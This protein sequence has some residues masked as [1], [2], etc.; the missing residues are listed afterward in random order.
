[1]ELLT[2]TELVTF[3]RCEERH[4]I[5]YNKRL[6]P[7][8]E[9]PALAMGSAVHAG[10]EH[11]SARVALD[12]MKS[13]DN[14]GWPGSSV[15]ERVRRSQ[16][17]AMVG[18]ALSQWSVWPDKHEVQFEVPLVN[19]KTGRS[20]KAHRLSGVFDG[21]WTGTHPAAPGEWVLGEWKTASAVNED[22]MRRLEIDF[23]VTTYMY[24]ASVLYKRPVRKMVY[25][26]IKKPTI[27]QKKTEH[28]GD[29]GAR[30]VLDY[31][32]RPEHYFFEEVVTRTDGQI[33]EWM[34]QAW[35]THRR[36]LQIQKGDVPA[37]RSTQSCL[38]RGRCPYFDLCT[39]AV[40][41]D[42]FKR[43][44]TKHREIRKGKSNGDDTQ[45]SNAS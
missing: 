16:V 17:A 7:F 41:E 40:V 32:D 27:R 18:G 2:Q 12:A 14:D 30:V 11:G 34:H 4:N 42:T 28:V 25:R 45:R 10:L 31:L 9:H 43:L 8:E 20:S 26:V 1:M 39:G 5:R 6:T 13:Q 38:N 22:Y 21:I 23:Q 24:A 15:S 3:S 36:I 35:A 33:E 29:Y 37:I 19:P 44:N